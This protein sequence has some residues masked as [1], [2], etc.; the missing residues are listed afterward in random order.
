MPV[1]AV[2]RLVRFT[3]GAALLITIAVFLAFIVRDA[4]V[5]AHT[6]VG[7]VVACSIVAL[8]VDPVVNLVG[9]FLPRFLSVIVVVLLM[10]ALIVVAVAGIT[11]ELLDSIDALQE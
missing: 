5:D 7:W 2:T 8:L 3:P 10:L 11:R 9:R 1:T 6:V 4:F